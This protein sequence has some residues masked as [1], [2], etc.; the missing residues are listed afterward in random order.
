MHTVRKLREEDAENSDWSYSL[1]PY[2]FTVSGVSGT[3]S[4]TFTGG[5]GG[6]LGTTASYTPPNGSLSGGG[7]L[8]PAGTV[9]DIAWDGTE[10]S[11]TYNSFS[12]S[13]GQYQSGSPNT[14]FVGSIVLPGLMAKTANWTATK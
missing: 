14:T 4:I 12:Y 3:G 5:N 8:G 1:G 9:D 2:N 7:N 10:L 11:F 6:A 13:A